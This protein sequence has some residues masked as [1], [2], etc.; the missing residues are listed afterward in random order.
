MKYLLLYFSIGGLIAGFNI[1][2]CP[3]DP[4]RTNIW[5]LLLWPVFLIFFLI[6][7]LDQLLLPKEKRDY[8]KRERRRRSD[9][10]FWR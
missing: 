2:A 9:G 1:I 10:G 4:P 3:N 8:L 5:L 6:A 7:L